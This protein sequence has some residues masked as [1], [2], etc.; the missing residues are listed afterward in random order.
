MKFFKILLIFFGFA[1]ISCSKEF[2]I[3]EERIINADA[4]PEN[5]MSHART[6][7]EKRFSPLNQISPDTISDLGLAW[8]FTTDTN[9]GHE[10]SPIVVDGVMFTTSAWSV[11]YA[12]N[13]A[14]GELLWKY[15]PLVDKEWGYNACCDVVNRGVA[16]WE[17]KVLLGA[18]DGR[19]IALNA[20]DGSLLW[21][22]LTID[23]EKPYTITGAPRVLKD[24]VLIGNGGAELG[25]RGYVTAYNIKNGKKIWRFYT[26]PG[27]PSLDFEN[28]ILEKASKTW[29]GGEWWKIG[30]GGTVWDSMAFDPELDLL[31]IGVGNGSPW[32]RYIRSPGGGDNLFLSSIVALKPDTGEYIW[33]YQTTPGD[34][35]DYTAT[36]HMILA[37]IEIDQK[38]RKV[39]MQAPKNGFFYVV[40]RK[41]GEFISAKNYVPVN[42]ALKI[43]EETGRPIENNKTNYKGTVKEVKPGPL[44][45]HNWHPMSYSPE[46][47]LAYIPA[48]ELSFLYGDTEDF[49]YDKNTWNTGIDIAATIPP[50]DPNELQELLTSLKGHLSAWNPVT[51][52]EVWRAQYEWPWNGGVLS[53]AGNLVFQGTSD[54]RLIAYTADKGTKVWEIETYN[55]IGAPP[56]TYSIDG[57]QYI[58][59]IIGYGGAFPLTSGVPSPNMGAKSN[60]QVLTFKLNGKE[61]ILKPK[62]YKSMIKPPPSLADF[63]T[64]SKG[65][66]EFHQHCQFCHGAGAG[67]GGV[68]P[69]L[70][71]M[72]EETHKTFLGIVLGGAHKNKGMISFK[73]MLTEDQALAI[74]E[75]LISQANATYLMQKGQD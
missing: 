10:A 21:E 54:G 61:T 1:L 7:D 19:L 52:K 49:V 48:Q 73:D 53:T 66:Y 55:G 28:P 67:G 9:R 60:G 71:M 3:S 41:N 14:T 31:Y 38:V 23:K 46:T 74:H 17:G 29:K 62:T 27:D 12:L 56:I 40:D 6:Y 18:L 50:K 8:K 2:N 68:I 69:D 57:V 43:D 37:D 64:I 16:V 4:E 22:T 70:Q 63:A 59:V 26:V 15:D 5:W 47:G 65:E 72:T 20:T 45:G 34:T 30:G 58:S 35:W 25:V 44:G 13:A 24:M 33:H 75:Y 51:Q 11:V 39:I 42:W 32:N 36:Q